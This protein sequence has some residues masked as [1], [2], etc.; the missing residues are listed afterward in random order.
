MTSIQK[1]MLKTFL[2]LRLGLGVV[3]LVFPFLLWIGGELYNVPLAGSMSAYYH[4]NKDCPNPRILDPPYPA[5]C[6][7]K[8]TGPMR[9]WFVGVLFFIGGG[10]YFLRGFSKWE[11]IALNIA[12]VMALGVALVPMAWPG[13]TVGFPFHYT[14]AVTFFLAVAFTCVFCSEKTLKEMPP[15]PDRD[16]VI[17]A[18]RLKYRVLAVAMVFSPLAAYVFN[19]YTYK[20]S[21]GFFL[22]AFGIFAFGMYWLVKTG[23][24]KR[25]EVERKALR[26][27]LQ[28]DTETLK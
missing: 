15:V 3:G 21:L 18:Y 2:V 4:A 5:P 11:D 7:P 10:L 27:E 25:S 9:N 26:G 20:H 17:A 14:F 22:E 19:A 8:G 13:K 12:G 16:K 1:H 23:E 6:C 24:L 28:M